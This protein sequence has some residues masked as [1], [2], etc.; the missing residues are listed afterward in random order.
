MRKDFYDKP[1]NQM[2]DD[3]FKEY[4]NSEEYDKLMTADLTPAER[5][6]MGRPTKQP[7]KWTPEQREA[8]R[9]SLTPSQRATYDFVREME[10]YRR[11]TSGT[12]PRP[13]KRIS[14]EN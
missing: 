8:Y 2:T 9:A 13:V 4:I 14:S 10:V 1:F 6:A 12:L 3:E 11:D 7:P 5:A